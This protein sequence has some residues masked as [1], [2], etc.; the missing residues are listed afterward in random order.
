MNKNEICFI[1]AK[2]KDDYVFDGIK[3]SGYDIFI[4]YKDYNLILRCLRE[5]WFS[6]GL[7]KELW[8]NPVVKK[9]KNKKLIIVK[10]PLIIPEFLAWVKDNN[11]EARVLLSYDNRV[12]R[13]LNPDSIDRNKIELWSYDQDDCEKYNLKNKGTGYLDIYSIEDKNPKKI[14]VLYL[15]RD[16]GRLN[17]LLDLQKQLE[18][19]GLKTYFHICAD[20][21]YLKYKNKNYK[22]EIPYSEYLLMLSESKAI[23]NIV[24]DG[25]TS[26][27]QREMEAIF[28]N[29]KCITNNIGLVK[30]DFYDSNR[31]F[32]LGKDD[33]KDLPLFISKD[34][35]ALNPNRLIQYK[36]DQVV[37]RLYS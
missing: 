34:V 35:D 25:Q 6:V 20:R 31:Y 8:F 32:I 21:S 15:G 12:Q 26:V 4:P 29:R 5:L 37:D 16:K 10:D 3:K 19:M 18:N 28:H 13:S 17:Y 11:P 14:D 30:C 2:H 36:L 9:L 22:K 7:P 1:R 24:P 23:L 33:M 27:T